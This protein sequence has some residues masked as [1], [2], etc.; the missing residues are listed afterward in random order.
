[1]KTLTTFAILMLLFSCSKSDPITERNEE[2]KTNFT[3]FLSAQM[4]GDERMTTEIDS[5][6]ILKVDTLTEKDCVEWTMRN[7]EDK[8]TAIDK[9]AHDD[10]FQLE[11]AKALH[12]D[13][14]MLEEYKRTADE[15]QA[16]K[17]AMIRR[18]A[19][20]KNNLP[21][22]DNKKFKYYSVSMDI[23]LT[24]KGAARKLSTILPATS[25][26]KPVDM[27]EFQ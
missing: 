19:E 25:G 13:N 27:K 2:L 11:N 20:M 5:I 26:L 1:M 8:F 12:F 14:Y 23:Y 3:N 15:S 7:M 4:S 17:D 10:A 6:V 16:E 9:K 18:Y 24:E 22:L 21:K